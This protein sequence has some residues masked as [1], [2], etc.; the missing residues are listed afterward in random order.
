MGDFHQQ[1]EKMLFDAAATAVREKATSTLEEVRAGLHE[2]ARRVLAFWHQLDERQEAEGVLN[3]H[4]VDRYEAVRAQELID[5]GAACAEMDAW[6]EAC[7]GQA[8]MRNAAV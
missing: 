2:E 8:S 4:I 1:M 5:W 3:G 7:V 6:K